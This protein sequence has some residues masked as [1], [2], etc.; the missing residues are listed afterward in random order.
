MV[1]FFSA[2]CDWLYAKKRCVCPPGLLCGR[3]EAWARE[4]LGEDLFGT[5]LLEVGHAV[6][7][8]AGRFVGGCEGRAHGHLSVR[9]KLSMQRFY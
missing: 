6:F 7:L 4:D 8:F 2:T 1:L 3:Q 5:S 9:T